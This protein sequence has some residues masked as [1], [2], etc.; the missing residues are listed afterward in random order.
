M[1]TTLAPAELHARSADST[2]VVDV[3][4]PGEF[5]AGHVPGAVNVPADHLDALLPDL[6]EAAERR[7]IVVVCAAGQRSAAACAK[8][9]DAGVEAVGLAGGTQAWTADGLPV[10]T[11]AHAG[12]GVWAMDR[13]VRFTAGSLVL[14]GLALGQ[15]APKARLLAAGIASGLVYSGLSNT[16]GMAAMLGKLPFN[17]PAPGALDAARAALRA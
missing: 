6:R 2:L 11:A 7:R 8:L 5:A 3:R 9:A 4:S 15:R 13:Q 1:S 12:R 10:D 16:C 17:R 14:L